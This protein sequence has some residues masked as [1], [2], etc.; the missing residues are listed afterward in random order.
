MNEPALFTTLSQ[1]F[2]DQISASDEHSFWYVTDAVLLEVM[3]AVKTEFGYH[4]LNL[5][6]A[7]DYED[8]VEMVYQV[9]NLH[10]TA[11]L[12]IKV[13][14]DPV[15]PVVPSLV[16]IWQAANVQERE[17]YD[18]MGVQFT[19]H[20]DLKRILLSE[21]FEGHPLKKDFTLVPADRQSVEVLIEGRLQ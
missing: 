4:M 14:C 2:S 10:T 3:Q 20:P 19:G 11:T 9:M 15:K 8:R 12:M 7:V 6:T 1:R 21:D 13:K 5:L 17:T 16:P 18:L